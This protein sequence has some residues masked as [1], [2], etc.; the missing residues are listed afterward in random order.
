MT[1]PSRPS[2]GIDPILNPG[3]DLDAGLT[4]AAW[5]ARDRTAG[6]PTRPG[7]QAHNAGITPGHKHRAPRP[8]NRRRATIGDLRRFARHLARRLVR[9]MNTEADAAG[10]ILGTILDRLDALERRVGR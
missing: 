8:R 5:L 1:L 10:S 6:L 7:P 3:A 9:R 2:P 4:Y